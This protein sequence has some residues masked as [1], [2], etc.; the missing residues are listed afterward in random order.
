MIPLAEAT[1]VLMSDRIQAAVW[2]VAGSNPGFSH[3]ELDLSMRGPVAATEGH[4]LR[5]LPS[6][7]DMRATEA[8]VVAEAATLPPSAHILLPWQ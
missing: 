7:G 1:V 8:S 6:G 5:E 3:Q 4:G 2:V